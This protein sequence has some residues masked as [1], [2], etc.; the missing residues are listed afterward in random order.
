MIWTEVESPIGSIRLV[1]N[2]DALAG[3]VLTGSAHDGKS[4]CRSGTD[5][6][7]RQACAELKQY[8]EGRRTTFGVPIAING[9]QFQEASWEALRSIPYGQTRSYGEQAHAMGKPGAA[10]AVGQANRRN[11]LPIVVPCHRVLAANGGLGGYMGSWGEDAP[12]IK[13]WLLD[14]ERKNSQ[15]A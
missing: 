7:L 10:R 14:L 11:P 3:V 9:T 6:V 4:N 5:K 2:G 8:L 13:Q 12:D 1:S 15:P